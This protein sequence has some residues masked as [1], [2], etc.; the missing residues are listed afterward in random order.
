MDNFTPIYADSTHF[1]LRIRRCPKS[2]GFC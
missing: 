1:Q 2:I